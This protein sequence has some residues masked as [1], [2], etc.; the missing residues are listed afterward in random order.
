MKEV[1]WS[2]APEEATHWGCPLVVS[3]GDWEEMFYQF[4][5]GGWRG[6][7]PQNGWS[8]WSSSWFK[9][10]ISTFNDERLPTLIKRPLDAPIDTLGMY[11]PD[12]N[13]RKLGKIQMELVDMGFPNAMYA[14][15]Q[16]MTWAAEN[17]GYKPN[18]WKN[19]PD[20]FMAFTGASGRHRVKR[21]KGED[22]D[23]ESGLLH[24]AHEAFNILALLETTLLGDNK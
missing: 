13:T 24:L 9:E 10:D 12:L 15:A 6:F 18:D 3:D 22:L 2:K 8:S 16:V 19:L 1:D 5:N 4:L 17:K 20:S 7:S 11:R 14:I 23:D 21:L